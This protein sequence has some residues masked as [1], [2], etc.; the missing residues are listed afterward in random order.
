M[1][2]RLAAADRQQEILRAATAV[3]ARS[4]YHDAGVADIAREAGVSEPLLYRHFASKKAIF[5]TIL[6]HVGNRILEIWED[7]IAGAPD[8]PTALRRA[9]EV[10]LSNL[11]S[12]GAEAQLQ[13]RALAEADD[14]EVR[15]VLTANHRAYLKFFEGLVERGRAE[16]TLRADVDPR[17]VAFLLDAAGFTFALGQLLDLDDPDGSRTKGLIDDLLGWI[18][19]PDHPSSQKGPP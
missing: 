18:S 13:F 1:A 14:P 19:I 3:F 10:Y 4:G 12:H 16:G 11:R 8:A 7:A 5:S 15:A 6:A 2:R 17:A 9:G